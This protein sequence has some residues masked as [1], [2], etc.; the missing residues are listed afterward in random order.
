MKILITGANGYIGKSLY[1]YL[2]NKH[3]VFKLSRDICDLTNTENVNKY[4]KNKYFD[5]VLHCAIEGGSRLKADTNKVLDNNLKMYYN[6]LNNEKYFNKLINFGSGAELIAQNTKYGLSKHIIRQSIL[7]KNNFYNLRIFAVFDENELDSRF[8]K[9]N[10]KRY[11][12]MQSIE[13]YENKLI[14]FFYMKDLFLIVDYFLNEKNL[15][16]E[17]DCC[18]KEKLTLYKVATYINNLDNYKVN[19]INEDKIYSPY[20][21]N[22]VN[23]PIKLFGLKYGIKEVFNKLLKNNL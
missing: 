7:D 2:I 3:T 9:S 6:L 1:T 18:Y 5:V 17:I 19:I 4:F 15:P 22:E 20:I 14:D 23:L 16:K 12:N 11:I 13:I 10:I 8:I 21:G